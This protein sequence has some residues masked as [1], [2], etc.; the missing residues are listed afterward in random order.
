MSVKAS[1]SAGQ[2]FLRR[3]VSWRSGDL[4]ARCPGGLSRE[5]GAPGASWGQWVPQSCS[6]DGP[7]MGAVRT[8]HSGDTS[9]M[10]P[11]AGWD[12][13]Q[14]VQRARGG[15]PQCPPLTPAQTQA[16]ASE[17]VQRGKCQHPLSRGLHEATGCGDRWPSAQRGRACGQ[18]LSQELDSEWGPRCQACEASQP[19]ERRSW[20]KHTGALAQLCRWCP[21]PLPC[22]ARALVWPP[23]CHSLAAGFP[24]SEPGETPHLYGFC[25]KWG[26]GGGKQKPQA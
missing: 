1:V 11:R 6:L 12:G 15:S 18:L 19:R 7:Q 10:G 13:R 14:G 2:R 9:R 3:R 21:R 16:A 5:G 4:S 23:I 8:T 24:V 25:L 17:V 22:G 26:L 20:T